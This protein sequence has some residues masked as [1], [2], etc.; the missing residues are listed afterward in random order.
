MAPGV[1]Q[2]WLRHESSDVHWAQEDDASGVD[3]SGVEAS[4][5]EASFGDV[6][7]AHAADSPATITPRRRSLVP[8][9]VTPSGRRERRATSV[10]P[11]PQ[12]YRN[13]IDSRGRGAIWR[14]AAALTDDSQIKK[15]D[16]RTS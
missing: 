3:A 11:A 16:L 12:R 9:I 13:T 7:P 14:V 10:D 1:A 6:A 2:G 8:I 5:V 4:G 15:A